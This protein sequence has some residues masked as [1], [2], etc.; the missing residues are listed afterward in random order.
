[1]GWSSIRCRKPSGLDYARASRLWKASPPLRGTERVPLRG[2][3]SG[4][5][6]NL[7]REPNG[8]F[9]VEWR[10]NRLAILHAV[11]DVTIN[12]TLGH[13]KR[14]ML[15]DVATSVCPT[16]LRI[17]SGFRYAK[18]YTHD[19]I[20][21]T[22]TDIDVRL[23]QEIPSDLTPFAT[24]RFVTYERDRKETSRL[25]ADSG[26][27]AYAKWA[28]MFERLGGREHISYNSTYSDQDFRRV[29]HDIKNKNVERYQN[30]YA[31]CFYTGSNIKRLVEKEYNMKGVRVEHPVVMDID[32][33]SK[34]VARSIRYDYENL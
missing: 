17:H 8:D 21:I 14:G 26:Y 23:P 13:N 27:T 9:S 6:L 28:Q 12:T 4:R 10:K 16:W 32:D 25:Y 3:R 31:Y 7:L 2:V 19:S 30:I 1:M 5:D 18:I 15:Y 22:H 11:G 20:A 33:Y 29:L 24:A 34:A